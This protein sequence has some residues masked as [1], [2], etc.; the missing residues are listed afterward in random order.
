MFIHSSLYRRI[1]PLR[2]GASIR[3]LDGRDRELL[4]EYI[5]RFPADIRARE[6][7]ALHKAVVYGITSQ[8]RTI[9]FDHAL[10]CKSLAD[11]VSKGDTLTE[12]EVRDVNHVLYSHKYVE[13]LRTLLPFPIKAEHTLQARA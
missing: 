2:T 5:R 11:K 9:I 10:C 7:E 8:G 3:Y 6:V 1:Y 4:V 13:P 12:A